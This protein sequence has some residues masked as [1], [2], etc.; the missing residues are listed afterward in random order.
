MNG[1]TRVAAGVAAGY[2]MGRTKK[3][4]LA[5]MVTAAGITGSLAKSPGELAR[6][7]VGGLGASEPVEGLIGTVR[8]ELKSAAAAAAT[9]RIDA[10]TNRLSG[11]S[12]ADEDGAE[13]EQ[14]DE[15]GQQ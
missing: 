2:L 1:G 15:A 9:R 11:S 10:L 12:G 7:A 6:R 14:H 5:L 3:M 8:G 13:Q 4:K